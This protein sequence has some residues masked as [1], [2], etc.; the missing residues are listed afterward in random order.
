MYWN[1]SSDELIRSLGVNRESKVRKLVI[2][3]T[4]GWDK[5]SRKC[6][7]LFF[8]TQGATA[9]KPNEWEKKK[10]LTFLTYTSTK[11][12]LLGFVTACTKLTEL[13]V[14]F[15]N[16]TEHGLCLP[17]V[18]TASASTIEILVACKSLP[19]F[20]TLQIVPFPFRAS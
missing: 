14:I 17:P 18:E 4:P 9:Y 11:K 15:S 6:F 10:K 1:A 20:E 7:L 5:P 3:L 2:P 8:S 16:V 12:N 19:D 13:T